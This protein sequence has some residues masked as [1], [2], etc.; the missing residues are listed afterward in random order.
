VSWL[1]A[2]LVVLGRKRESDLSIASVEPAR[3][4]QKRENAEQ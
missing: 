2:N 1:E 3:S 4:L